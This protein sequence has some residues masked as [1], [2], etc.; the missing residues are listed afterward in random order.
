M[1]RSHWFYFLLTLLVGACAGLGVLISY[2]PDLKPSYP[3]LVLAGISVWGAVILSQVERLKGHTVRTHGLFMAF[4]CL[5]SILF[6]LFAFVGLL[7]IGIGLFDY[8][9]EHGVSA[10]M[11]LRVHQAA[12]L[13]FALQVLFVTLLVWRGT[14]FVV[15]DG[16]VVIVPNGAMFY[17]G[18][19]YEIWLFAKALPRVESVV[20]NLSW[21]SQPVEFKDGSFKVLFSTAARLP[22]EEMRSATP[23][24]LYEWTDEIRTRIEQAVR[25]EA[26]NLTFGQFLTGYRQVK[27]RTVVAHGLI[28]H[29]G[30]NLS[31]SLADAQ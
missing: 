28:V 5:F 20:L 30:E 6:S 9:G 22:V 31:L 14:K 3:H 26:G 4:L 27:T 19:E 8:T 10:G 1:Q 13:L 16:H 7:E 25:K 23:H 24:F 12:Y 15:A 29:W 21:Q 2:S 18:D 11:A 17:P